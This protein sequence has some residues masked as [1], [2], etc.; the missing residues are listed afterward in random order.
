MV[1]ASAVLCAE[2]KNYYDKI[3][4]KLKNK[5]NKQQVNVTTN[6]AQTDEEKFDKLKNLDEIDDTMNKY[7]S[8]NDII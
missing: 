1:T 7:G 3:I 2:I 6:I 4:N 5:I 8:L